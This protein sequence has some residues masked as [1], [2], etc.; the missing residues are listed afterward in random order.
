MYMMCTVNVL[1]A[2]IAHHVVKQV[3]FRVFDILAGRYQQTK[4]PA[5]NTCR[6]YIHMY[7]YAQLSVCA[8]Y[9]YMYVFVYACEHEYKKGP[10]VKNV[11]CVGQNLLR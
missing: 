3:H 8:Y 10:R 4:T 11:S 9:M 7:M 1:C 6:L 5:G 2:S